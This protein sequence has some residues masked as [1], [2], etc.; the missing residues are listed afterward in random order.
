MK[1]IHTGRL[2][3]IRKD[4]TRAEKDFSFVSSAITREAL[5][6]TAWTMAAEECYEDETIMTNL[7]LV[8]RE[9]L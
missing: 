5:V 1:A 2:S 8:D 4:G 3:H 6:E 9:P 7:L